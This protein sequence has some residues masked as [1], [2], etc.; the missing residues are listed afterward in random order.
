MENKVSLFIHR[1]QNAKGIINLFVTRL[2][3]LK[4]HWLMFLA[5]SAIV[6]VILNYVQ[7]ALASNTTVTSAT[8]S[9]G[10]FGG[11][12]ISTVA[13]FVAILAAAWLVKL[14]SK[15]VAIPTV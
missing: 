1:E 8:S 7:P 9:L 4:M 15:S 2:E 10:S 14:V 3:D 6:A 12:A 11:I 13:I 5:L